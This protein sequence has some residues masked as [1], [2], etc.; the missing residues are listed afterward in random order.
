LDPNR[1]A[2]L[3]RVEPRD[4]GY[5]LRDPGGLRLGVPC[6]VEFALEL[7]EQLRRVGRVRVWVL[8]K[9]RLGCRPETREVF[10][11]SLRGRLLDGER[12]RRW[13]AE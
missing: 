8:R 9:E 5:L 4:L 6:A 11:R 10:A 12:V 7:Q 1:A 2:Q 3:L 13:P